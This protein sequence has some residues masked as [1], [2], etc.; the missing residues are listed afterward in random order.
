[1][2]ENEGQRYLDQ[3][4]ARVLRQPCKLGDELKLVLVARQGE[5]VASRYPAR[6]AA[7]VVFADAESA[8]EPATCERAPWEHAH[9]VGLRRRKDVTLDTADEQRVRRLLRH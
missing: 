9:A 8:R 7:R 3:G 6:A 2:L 1:M 5:V 4:V